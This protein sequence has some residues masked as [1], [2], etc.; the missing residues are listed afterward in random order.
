MTLKTSFFKPGIYKSTIKRYLWGSILYFIALFLS[1]PL[2]VLLS[3]ETHYLYVPDNYFM[4]NPLILRSNYMVFPILLAIA[5]PSVVSVMIFRFIHSKN[6]TVFVH[7]LPVTRKANYISSILAAFTLM[8]VPVVLNG[9]I[10]VFVSLFGYG[11]Y[12]QP[13]HCILWTGYNLY[14]LF[15]MF[16]CAVFASNLTGNGFAAVGINILIHV[17]L[18]ILVASFGTMAEK[19]IY[20]YT[21]MDTIFET[22]ANNNFAYFTFGLSDKYFREKIEVWKYIEFSL[23]AIVLYVSSYY[24]YKNRKLETAGDVAAFACLHSILKYSVT[25]LAASLCFVVFSSYIGEN[26]I[27]FAI[28]VIIISLVAYVASEM[29]LKKTLNV[30]YSWKGYLVFS[31]LFA[32]MLAFVSQT[33]FFGFETR[34]PE[35]EE[36][37]QATVYNYYHRQEEPFS[38]NEKIIDMTLSLHEEFAGGQIPEI[39]GRAYYGDEEPLTNLHIKYKLKN[40]KIFERKYT[41][42]H[43]KCN[44]VM[45]ELYKVEDYKK[46]CEIIFTEDSQITNAFVDHEYAIGNYRELIEEVRKDVLSLGYNELYSQDTRGGETIYS[47]RLQY[48]TEAEHLSEG[49]A[50]VNYNYLSINKRYVNAIKWLDENGYSKYKR[51]VTTTE[52]KD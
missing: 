51:A 24:L 13:T 35:K 3:A 30:F 45:E 34:M 6:Q 29:L 44:K 11:D 49:E 40:G 25:F 22:I 14:T 39:I 18:F 20:G 2:S 37:K 41:V 9:I 31:V 36:I 15:I 17:F 38:E 8:A 48:N 32:L 52:Y 42:T 28:I 16:S 26:N 33:T 4:D 27:V 50:I 7:S 5:V 21:Q 12:F 10:L 19:F 1:T 23:A 43:D 46:K 47:I